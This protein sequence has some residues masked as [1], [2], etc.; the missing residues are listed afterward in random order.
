MSPISCNISRVYLLACEKGTYGIDCAE[1]CGNCRYGDCDIKTGRCYGGCA[2]G[3]TGD[4]CKESK[5][6]QYCIRNVVIV[7]M[8]IVT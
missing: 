6:L 5:W 7:A 2:A 3:Y 1:K 4:T 8:V